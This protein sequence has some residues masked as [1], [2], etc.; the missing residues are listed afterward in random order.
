[1]LKSILIAFFFLL[2]YISCSH[3]QFIKTENWNRISSNYDAYIDMVYKKVDGLELKLDLYVPKDRTTLKPLFINFHGGGWRKG[4]KDSSWGQINTFL[5]NG[6][7]VANVDYRLLDVAKAPAAV[8]DCKCA[9]IWLVANSKNF[10][11]DPFNVV[12]AGSSAGG[13]LAL[14]TGMI[15]LD[16]EIS[17]T[18][19]DP[20]NFK[21][22][23]ILN[24][25]GITNLNEILEGI[26]KKP[27][28]VDWLGE[29]PLR[30]KMSTLVSPIT[31]IN[32]DTPPIFTVHGDSDPTV[33]Y[34]Q[35][36]QLHAIL[37]K[38]GI[39]NNLYT[40]VGGLHGKF[41][42]DENFK[43]MKKISEFLLELGIEIKIK[44]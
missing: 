18:C 33:P 21:I 23:A 14:T 3:G 7:V 13:H 31:Y 26:N 17:F 25:Y 5:K 2:V 4:T 41:S 24:F 36:I 38:F 11:I 42:K 20:Q 1:M 6:W 10:S 22:V 40:V 32:K 27:F 37:D 29:N 12:V 28:V 35:A 30:E 43:V 19:T 39:K 15:P 44:E 8:Q 34:S 9:L 16:G